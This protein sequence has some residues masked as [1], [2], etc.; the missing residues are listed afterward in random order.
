LEGQALGNEKAARGYSRD[1]RPEC[2][3]VNIGLVVTPEGLAIGY[4]IFAGNTADVTTVEEME[5]NYGQAQRIWV[6]ERG[7]ISEANIDFLRERKARYLVG[8]PSHGPPGR[9]AA[10][11]DR[12]F[13]ALGSRRL[14]P[15]GDRAPNAQPNEPGDIFS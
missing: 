13:A 8:T 5:E 2:K 10:D 1:H 7:M 6:M 11:P 15:V 12:G 9:Y 4:E 14:C 3:Q